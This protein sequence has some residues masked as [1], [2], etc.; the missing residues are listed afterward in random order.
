MTWS[1]GSRSCWVFQIH[2]A[3]LDLWPSIFAI[4]FLYSLLKLGT[5]GWHLA[6]FSTSSRATCSTGK[7]CFQVIIDISTA[8]QVSVVLQSQISV[9]VQLAAD[10][11][12]V[13]AALPCNDT[14]CNKCVPTGHISFPTTRKNHMWSCL[15]VLHILSATF[16]GLELS[17]SHSKGWGGQEAKLSCVPRRKGIRLMIHP[18]VPGINEDSAMMDWHCLSPVKLW[19][20][21]FCVVYFPFCHLCP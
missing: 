13:L 8:Q 18:R 12:F 5:S 3:L 21:S 15:N 7:I 9:V 19:H 6:L 4:S 17:H 14:P 16:L 1:L 10:C 2:K 20:G 11:S